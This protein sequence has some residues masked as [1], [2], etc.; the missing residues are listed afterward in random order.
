MSR[1]EEVNRWSLTLPG[2]EERARVEG[3]AIANQERFEGSGRPNDRVRLPRGRHC[4]GKYAVGHG[5]VNKRGP[6][7]S[8][9]C[10]DQEVDF[11]VLQTLRETGESE[12]GGDLLEGPTNV[13]AAALLRL[14]IFCR[15]RA[16]PSQAKKGHRP[17]GTLN[18]LGLVG[19]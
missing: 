13:R 5:T 6:T 11:R 10:G 14:A 3:P 15:P 16:W 2:G 4:H 18:Q 19:D 8:T 12:E 17:D 9:Q 1:E 7:Q